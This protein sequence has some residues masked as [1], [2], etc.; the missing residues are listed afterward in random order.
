MTLDRGHVTDPKFR[1]SSERLEAFTTGRLI[2]PWFASPC[3]QEM[4]GRVQDGV[5]CSGFFLPVPF[6]RKGG[7]IY[8]PTEINS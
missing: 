5:G 8:T 6:L 1:A 7:L 4:M 3:V 2:H